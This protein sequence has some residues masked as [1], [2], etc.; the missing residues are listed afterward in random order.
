MEDS[1]ITIDQKTTQDK[2]VKKYTDWFPTLNLSYEINEKESVTLGYSRRLRRPRS[3]FI[4]PFPSRSSILNIFQGNPDLDPTYSNAYDLGY[5]KRWDKLTLNSSVYYQKAIKVFT[6]IQEDSGDTVTLGN[7]EFSVVRTNPV[8][9]SEN[10]QWGTEFTVSYFPSRKFRFNGNF[11]LFSTEIIGDY[12]GVTY[13]ASNLSWFARF[14]SAIKLPGNIDWQLR[15]FYRGPRENAQNKS[16]GI[17]SMSGALNKEIFDKKGTIAF[18]V[19]DIFN[20]Q[21]RISEAFTSTFYRYSEFQWRQPTYILSMTYRLNQ[22][23]N[24]RRSR[25]GNNFD[26]GGGD[27][28]DF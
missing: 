22:N 21:R 17:F 9:L 28:F 23:R 10:I 14:N 20:S 27:Q 19:S 16:K 4:N 24:E 26:S 13:D 8:N 15:M 5:L 1:N 2:T 25:R 18:R 3:R 11:N 7:E 6:F 12:N